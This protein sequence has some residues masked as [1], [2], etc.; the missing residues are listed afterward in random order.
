V[1]DLRDIRRLYLSCKSA[2]FLQGRSSTNLLSGIDNPIPDAF[3][4][5]HFLNLTLLE[6][7][8]CRLTSLPTDFAAVVPNCRVLIL[9][10][11]FLTTLAPV[12][13]A[14]RL[15]VLS[16]VGNRLDKVKDL[17][18]IWLECSELE[19]LDLR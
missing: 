10:N 13:G 4:N 8:G 16:A 9:D 5:E 7:S 17:L 12:A 1:K 3:P 11:N 15:R 18:A 6:L 2:S 14:K 19:T